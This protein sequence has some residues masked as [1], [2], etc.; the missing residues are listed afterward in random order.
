MAANGLGCLIMTAVIDEAFRERLV[1]APAQVVGDFD[2]TNDE[3]EALTSIRAGS[4]TEF[5]AR[6]H[7]WLEQ[8]D[9]FHLGRRQDRSSPPYGGE[10]L[11][12][13]L[14]GVAESSTTG[15]RRYASGLPDSRLL[16]EEVSQVVRTRIT[17]DKDVSL[18]CQELYV[19]SRG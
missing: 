4:F 18:P 15:T 16:C 17:I 14:G 8:R 10:G 19:T 5:A 3:Q 7:R 1:A 13:D 2:L 11:L 6:L 9:P 12:A